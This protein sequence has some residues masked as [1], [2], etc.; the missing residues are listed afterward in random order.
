VADV[1]YVPE[2]KM[3]LLSVSTLE[4][5]GFAVLFQNGQLLIHSEGASPNTVVSIGVREGKVY[6]LKGKPVSESK[7]ILDHGSM[8]VAEDEKQEALKGTQCSETP[9]VGSQPS[10]AKELA[11]SISVRKPSWYEMTLMDAHEQV[12][13][14]RSTLRESKPST[15]FPNFMRLICYIIEE[16]AIQQEQQDALI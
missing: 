12:E 2:L 7:G 11:P 4:D 16:A 3:N 15:K 13:D 14:P 8:S 5:K 10:G 6:R 9:N 1:L